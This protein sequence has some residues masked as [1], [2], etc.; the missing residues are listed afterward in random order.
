MLLDGFDPN[1]R[2][3]GS[4]ISNRDKAYLDMEKT[5]LHDHSI[6]FNEALVY[7]KIAHMLFHIPM[8]H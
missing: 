2:K 5:S 8:F 1:G 7:F 3:Y 4:V 6:V